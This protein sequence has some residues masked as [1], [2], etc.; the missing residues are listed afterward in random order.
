MPVY[1][2]DPPFRLSSVTR[3]IDSNPNTSN[4]SLLSIGTHVGTHVDPPRHFDSTQADVAMLDLHVLCGS[5]R[6][7]D[8]R[9]KGRCIDESL[10]AC[11]DLRGVERLLLRTDSEGWASGGCD[12][13]FDKDYAHL[14]LDAAL[15]AKQMGLKLI[16]ID[17]PSVE[18][19]DSPGMLVHR[20]L[21]TTPPIVVVVEG[22]ELSG[23]E[24]GNYDLTCLPLK[25]VGGDGAPAR[26]ILRALP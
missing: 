23:V 2:G 17:S 8:L 15:Y 11:F 16:G 14:T 9:G 18:S 3:I 26:A 19:F 5:A 6:L 20:S 21:L 25:L 12:E 7:L 10:F 4:T 24:A 1:E 13:S 22:L